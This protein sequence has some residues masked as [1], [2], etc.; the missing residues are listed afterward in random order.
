MSQPGF[1]TVGHGCLLLA[2]K[3]QPRASANEIVG[4]QG[5]ELRVR[6]TA[7]PVDSAANEALLRLLTQT[8]GCRPNQVQLARGHH[9]RHKLVQ[10]RGISMET[11]LSRLN[12]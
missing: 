6:V 11:A 1:L 7:A 3:L 4:R 5:N 8:L 12:A 10:L 9:S 2:V